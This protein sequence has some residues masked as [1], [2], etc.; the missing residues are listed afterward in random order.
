MIAVPAPFGVARADTERT[1]NVSGCLLVGHKAAAT[2]PHGATRLIAA[3]WPGNDVA[4][5]AVS[6]AAR[7]FDCGI[8]DASTSQEH[9]RAKDV[10]VGVLR[11][12]AQVRGPAVAARGLVLREPAE[13]VFLLRAVPLSRGDLGPVG[14]ELADAGGELAD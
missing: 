2:S 4:P 3:A 11:S 5:A 7:T 13:P 6:C 10:V 9:R 8:P 1:A 12:S 14:R